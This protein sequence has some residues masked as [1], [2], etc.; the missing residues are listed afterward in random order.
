MAVSSPHGKAH[1][2]APAHQLPLQAYLGGDGGR[3][4]GVG[5]KVRQ[6]HAQVEGAQ[7]Q[8]LAVCGG[9]GGSGEGRGRS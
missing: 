7:K 5:T 4:G 1:T 9:A 6:Q 8:P 2:H 3:A